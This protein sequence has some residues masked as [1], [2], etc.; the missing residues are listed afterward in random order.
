MPGGR[1]AGLR[2]ASRYVAV[3]LLWWLFGR[4]KAE[5][6]ETPIAP[7]DEPKKP[8]EAVKP[9]IIAAAPARF[10]PKE[11]APAPVAAPPPP[12]PP[13]PEPVAETPPAPEP[14]P[15]PEDVLLLREIRDSLRK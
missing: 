7:S 14:E 8:L 9:E 15:T 10:K 1:A 12:P 11:P 2:A 13:V 5:E 6:I 4:N 3:V